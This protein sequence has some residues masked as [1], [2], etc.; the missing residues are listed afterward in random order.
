MS[1]NNG[2]INELPMLDIPGIKDMVKHLV[3]KLNKVLF[4]RGT[5][6]V[7]K[8]Q[9]IHQVVAELDNRKAMVALLGPETPY[10]GVMMVDVRL[11]GYE[12]V[13]LR[14]FPGVDKTTGQTVWFAPSTLPI[15]GNDQ[16]PDD[17]LILLFLDE[18]TSIKDDGVMSCAYQIT[19]DRGVGEHKL[20]PNVRIVLAGNLDDDNGIVNTI[21]MPLNNRMTHV[22]AVV[23]PEA[24]VQHMQTR[25]VPPIFQAFLL[26]CK[27]LVHTYDPRKPTAIVATPR[28]I[29]E[30]VDI[31]NDDMPDELKQ[32]AIEG[33]VGTGWAKQFQG[34][35]DVWRR[36]PSIKDI[37][38]D[39]MGIRLPEGSDAL[40]LTY[41]TVIKVTGAMALKNMTPLY[42]FITRLDAEYVVL[43]MTMA[44]SRDA[45]LFGTPEF[46]DYTKRYRDVYSR[47]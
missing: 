28:T 6:G 34:F 7:G 40:S 36:V 31:Y 26:A 46:M 23:S 20:K 29:M 41:A 43:C 9:G 2:M 24:V 47:T 42:K 33:T 44:T 1:K 8:S 14:G 37:I 38:A 17:K 35:H 27:D 12:S 16:Y 18:A 25:G 4:V 19:L 39:P 30:A 45:A 13:D 22:Q 3:L 11:G 10:R 32:A 21:P 15:V 5:F